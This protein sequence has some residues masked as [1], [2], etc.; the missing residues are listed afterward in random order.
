MKS[1]ISIV[2]LGVS[3]FQKSFD[4]Y[5]KGL[6]FK[7]HDYNPDDNYVMLE[8]EGTW[9]ALCPKD[10]LISDVTLP[11]GEPGLSSITLA[12]NVSSESAVDEVF[13]HAL[14]VGA[15]SIKEPQKAF[16]GGYSGYFA[17]PDGYLWEIAFNP[18]SD[19]T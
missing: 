1:K 2:T 13:N 10:K 5:T 12:H 9:L 3:N 17:D 11:I 6:G 7:P 15:K 4:F 8:M 19:L 16:W 18:F 14:S